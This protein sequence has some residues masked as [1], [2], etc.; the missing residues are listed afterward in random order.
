MLEMNNNYLLE[1]LTNLQKF[2]LCAERLHSSS[3]DDKIQ[4]VIAC[5]Q[6]FIPE[7]ETKTIVMPLIP[8]LIDFSCSLMNQGKIL[9]I[10]KQCSCS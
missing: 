2:I 9:S 3:G 7:G 10:G 4:F 8:V 1:I 6:G 5:L